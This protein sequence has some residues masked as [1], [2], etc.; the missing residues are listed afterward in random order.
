MGYGK[1]LADAIAAKG[2]S[3]SET[4]RRSGVNANTLN[5]IIRRDSSVRYDHAL[6][7]SNVL[8]IDIKLICKDNPYTQTD[9]E[10][11]PDLLPEAG[12][13]LTNLN[14][15]S[16]VKNRMHRLLNLFSYS[17]YPTLDQLLAKFYILDEEGRKQIF[18]YL[19]YQAMRHTDKDHEHNLKKI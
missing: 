19:D 8:G 10:T 15:N 6:R 3:V 17:E 11:L 4:S 12:G 7:L 13:L 1:N 5:A 9:V 18:D 2:W 16:Y 14:K